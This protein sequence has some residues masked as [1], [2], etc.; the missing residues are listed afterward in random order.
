MDTLR[1]TNIGLESPCPAGR[2]NCGAGNRGRRPDDCADCCSSN[3]LSA[4][5]GAKPG[6]FAGCACAGNQM[7]AAQRPKAAV[8]NPRPITGE[9]A[10][11]RRSTEADRPAL[12]GALAI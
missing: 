8:I 10:H 3:R 5:N 7:I 4:C 9:H 2:A 6:W 1:N 11:L 12:V